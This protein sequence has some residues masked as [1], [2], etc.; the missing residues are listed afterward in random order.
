MASQQI[1]NLNER[2]LVSMESMKDD[3]KN[4]RYKVVESISNSTISW[5]PQYK[6]AIT[7]GYSKGI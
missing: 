5:Y 4:N 7:L 1:W 2:K 3:T 6:T